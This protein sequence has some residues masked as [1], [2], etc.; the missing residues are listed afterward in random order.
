MATPAF[1][2]DFTIKTYRSFAELQADTAK[3]CE[4]VSHDC[5]V[6]SVGAAK[7]FTCSSVGAAC[8]PKEWRCYEKKLA[9]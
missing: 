1:A 2:D 9:Q 4:L 7:K 5:E 6:C 3:K 8:E